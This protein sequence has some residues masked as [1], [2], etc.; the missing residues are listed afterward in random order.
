VVIEA[1]NEI[2]EG[3]WIVPTVGDGYAYGQALATTLGLPWT[4]TH[5]RRITVKRGRDH[6]VQGTVTVEDGWTPCAKADLQIERES[7]TDWAPLG[8]TATKPDG[9]FRARIA[10]AGRYRFTVPTTSAYQQTCGAAIS[11]TLIVRR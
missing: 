9:S 4:T 6:L 5:T 8:A 2:S 7:G 11:R 3:S 10:T 1:W